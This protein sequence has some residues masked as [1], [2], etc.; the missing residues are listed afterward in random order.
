MT[1]VIFEDQNKMYLR[2][3]KT[4][5]QHMNK[6]IFTMMKKVLSLCSMEATNILMNKVRNLI[7]NMLQSHLL[8][9]IKALFA[10]QYTLP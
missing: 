3:L 5:R 1:L 2:Y 4:C 7:N 9:D 6:V 10:G 8:L